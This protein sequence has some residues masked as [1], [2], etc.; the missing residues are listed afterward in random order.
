MKYLVTFAFLAIIAI[1]FIKS[2][3]ASETGETR[4]LVV[5]L[6]DGWDD[7][8]A[9]LYRFER[10]GGEWSKIGTH[11]VAVVGKKGMAWGIGLYRK[12]GEGPVKKEGDGKTPAGVFRLVKAMGYEAAPPAGATLP[13]EQIKENLHCVDD[14]DSKYYNRIVS[15]AG[16]PAPAKDLWKSSEIMK[17]KDDMYKWL[18]VVDHNMIEPR[19]GAGSCIF[20]HIWRSAD[21]GT[22]GC[23]A[24]AE[25]DVT[26]LI[27]WLRQDADP[28]IVQMP[29]SEYERHWKDWK[30]APPEA[31]KQ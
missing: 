23:T 2:S 18:I 10:A 7:L 20:I 15:E 17:R 4:Q 9:R 22:A 24:M 11:H 6:T 27:A 31:V 12:N 14:P 13:Y 30:L 16:L 19:P 5:V 25:K 3:A 26:E 1:I 29:G 8:K 28:L 21:R